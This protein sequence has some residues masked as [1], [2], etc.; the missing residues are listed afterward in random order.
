MAKSLKYE[1][2]QILRDPRLDLH[3]NIDLERVAVQIEQWLSIWE[4][5]NNK[6]SLTAE[7]DALTVVQQHFFGSLLYRQGLGKAH[8]LLDIGSGAGFPGI[9]L[10]LVNPDLSMTL[11]ESQRKRAGFL[12]ETARALQLQDVEVIND[13]VENLEHNHRRKYESITFRYVDK[14]ES[15]LELAEPF[16]K[17]GGRVVII[18]EPEY[19]LP[20]RASLPLNCNA[21]IPVLTWSGSASKLMVFEGCFT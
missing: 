11:V 2:L 6:I 16:L 1:I 5:W 10:K 7:T 4:K 13:R 21:E 17:F 18:K 19:Q 12:Q 20:L 8:N 14:I 9:P 15:C 3:I